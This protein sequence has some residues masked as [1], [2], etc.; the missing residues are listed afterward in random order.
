MHI[1]DTDYIELESRRRAQLAALQWQTLAK[2]SRVE[3]RKAHLKFVYRIYLI[4]LLLIVLVATQ[5]WLITEIKA[6]QKFVIIYNYIILAIVFVHFL[7]LTLLQYMLRNKRS[8][9]L[10]NVYIFLMIE[11]GSITLSRPTVEADLT[12]FLYSSLFAVVMWGISF[13]LSTIGHTDTDRT[14][15]YL[16]LWSQKYYL[17]TATSLLMTMEFTFIWVQIG[18]SLF[19][20]FFISIFFIIWGRSLG[21]LK[22]YK[23]ESKY[24]NYYIVLNFLNMISLFAN[25]LIFIQRIV[26]Q[27]TD[28]DIGDEV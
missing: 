3:V 15:V 28:D 8:K 1:L 19:M 4:S 27:N 10:V 11:I 9:N 26:D 7:M 6:V 25:V 2:S 18:I 22:F 17:G 14:S 16:S 23:E 12:T 24:C 21:S 13:I 20:V 5:W